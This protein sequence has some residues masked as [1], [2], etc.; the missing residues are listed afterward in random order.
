MEKISNS[1]LRNF[2]YI[3]GIGIP[4]F[5]GW[6]LPKLSGHEFRL[7]TLFA[8]LPILIIGFFAPNKLL[9]LYKFW[10]KIGQILGWINSRIILGI[11]FL[12]VLQPIALIMKFTNYDPLRLR[13]KNSKTFKEFKDDTKVDL[14]R[15]F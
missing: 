15:I 2:S 11:I 12:L 9:N 4:L 10:I 5:V 8:G 14:S 7:W 1:S 3:A 13:I 6:L